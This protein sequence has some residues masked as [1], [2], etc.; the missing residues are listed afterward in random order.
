MEAYSCSREIKAKQLRGHYAPA[1]YVQSKTRSVSHLMHKQTN[2]QTKYVRASAGV[3]QR[4]LIH[5]S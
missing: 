1:I 2:K 3:N 5:I 4:M